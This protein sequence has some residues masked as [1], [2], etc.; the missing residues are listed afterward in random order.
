MFPPLGILYL[1]LSLVLVVTTLVFWISNRDRIREFTRFGLYVSG[2]YCAL[3]VVVLAVARQEIGDSFGL[4]TPAF[5][6]VFDFFKIALLV[7][8]GAYC[9]TFAGYCAFPLIRPGLGLAFAKE[10][11]PAQA[12]QRPDSDLRIRAIW[13]VVLVAGWLLYSKLLFLVFAPEISETLK[14]L[15]NQLQ[16]DQVTHLTPASALA[17]S[18]IAIV[19]ELAF[20]LGFQNLLARLFHWKGN[21]Y[22]LCILLTTIVWTIGHTGS[23]DPDWVKLAQVFP[24]GLALGWMFKKYGI[25]SCI[26]AHLLFNLTMPFLGL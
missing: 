10:L 4:T 12:L 24:A 13:V 20:R 19:E 23:L 5:G 2:I 11:E 21:R 14:N 1:I 8:V 25:E 3:S 26:A 16:V 17:V 6:L 9:A 22:W 18:S 7:A 15:M